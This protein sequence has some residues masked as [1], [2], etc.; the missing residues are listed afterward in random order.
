M[1][2][3]KKLMDLIADHLKENNK[4]VAAAESVTGGLLQAAFTVG[5]GASA[6]F[7][8]G[9]TAFNVGQKYRHLLVEPLHALA[10]DSVSLQIAEHM[11]T[12]V[13][14]MFASS[15]GLA[16]TGYAAT[17]KEKNIDKLFTYYAIANGPKILDSGIIN[18]NS[19]EG[20]DTQLFYVQE[21]MKKFLS[22]LK[23]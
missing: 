7:Q 4:T 23:S 5:E 13:C 20:L 18:S 8:G 3:D 9:I 14:S 12:H 6:F 10:C 16:T 19:D 11:A 1:V 15:Y 2:F 21:I 17:S 22:L